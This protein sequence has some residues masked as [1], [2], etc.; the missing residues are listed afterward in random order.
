MTLREEPL[1]SISNYLIHIDLNITLEIVYNFLIKY[2]YRIH[3]TVLSRC[4]DV[5]VTLSMFDS[6]AVSFHSHLD[7]VKDDVSVPK[8]YN[9]LCNSL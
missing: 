1:N 8:L 6:Q 7:G 5:S 2:T 9:L 3:Y 4:S